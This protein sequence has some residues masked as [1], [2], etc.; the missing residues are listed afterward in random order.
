MS[1]DPAQVVEQR[2]LRYQRHIN[3][4][5]EFGDSDIQM[6]YKDT[7]VFVTG[8]SG[9]IGK[10][11]IEKLFRACD[12]AKVYLL[13]RP[14]KG[15]T[16]EE[17]LK[18]ILEDPVFDS[19]RSKKPKFA[20]RIVPVTGDVADLK[21][22][23][24]DNDWNLL[25]QEVN[26]IFHVAATT[27]F[28]ECLRVTTLINVRGTREALTLAQACKNLRSFVHVSSA[29]A[30]ANSKNL[31]KEVMEQF[32]PSPVPPDVLIG[33]VENVDE[34][35]IK[36]FEDTFIKGYPNTYTFAKAVAE[37]EVKRWA[38]R[39]PVC[40]V[41][42]AIVISSYKEP[43]P[44]WAD[45]SCAHGA[46]GLVLGPG[47]GLVHVLYIQDDIRWSFVPVDY[48]NNG[49]IA[50]GYETG[51]NPPGDVKI[52]S[53]SSARNLCS[54]KLVN[55]GV[56][57]AGVN[58]PTPVAV[59][60]MYA[61]NTSN[62]LLFWLLTWL[63]HYIPGYLLDGVCVLLRRKPMF[64]KLFKKI[65]KMSLALSYFTTRSWI[66][67]D[68][69]ADKLYKSLSPVD[70]VIFDFDTTQID[71]EEY[72]SYWCMGLRKYIIKDGI[73]STEYA[74]KKQF[75]LHKLHLIVSLLYVY[76]IA[77]LLMFALSGLLYVFNLVFV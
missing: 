13:M 36:E 72:V 54:Y 34:E 33:L 44:G 18:V 12:I 56:K 16:V 35:R 22:G 43:S 45:M 63:Y 68:R 26:V 3:D 48:V 65:Y 59:W 32:Y 14:K 23:L 50:A 49:L 1:L 61:I 8:G 11:L 31:D 66:F 73:N 76:G 70:Q 19:L 10:Q 37:E 38:E 6:F 21:L 25:M 9:F 77:K 40:I 17:R 57:T 47:T 53:L 5:I 71:F 30:N 41:R 28:D 58:E 29:Y 4:A 46:S 69:N 67:D 20:E 52:Y 62:K 64:I 7:T 51:T 27:R 60:Y 55:T 42:P 74:I 39:V 24:S 2:G 15:K 75:W